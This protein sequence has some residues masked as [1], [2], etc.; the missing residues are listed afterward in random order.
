MDASILQPQVESLENL[1]RSRS[2]EKYVHKDM[3]ALLRQRNTG[4]LCWPF[5]ACESVGPSTQDRAEHLTVA[6]GHHLEVVIA[7]CHPPGVSGQV[8]GNSSDTQ[9]SF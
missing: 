9:C 4:A 7:T 3:I 2:A 6:T 5:E 8:A 1:S